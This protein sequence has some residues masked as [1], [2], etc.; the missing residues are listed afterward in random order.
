MNL[1]VILL[2]QH[3]VNKQNELVTTSLTLIDVHDIARSATTYGA[4]GYF[5]AHP[6]PEIRSLAR[7]L[8]EHWL[9]GYGSTYNSNR[10]EALSITRVVEGLDDAISEIVSDTGTIPLLVGTSAKNGDS[11]LSYEKAR[12]LFKENQPV[13]MMLGTGW[14]M[15]EQL[16]ARCDYILA[17]IN[18]PTPFNH[19]SVRSAAAIMLDRLLGK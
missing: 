14:G 19:L 18:G 1:Y 6:S 7:S 4:T 5:I 3:M 11:R 13:L 17:P 10:K 15:S 2:H 8:Q 9:K 16:L 12:E